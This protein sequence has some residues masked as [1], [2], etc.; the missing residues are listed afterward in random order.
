MNR[1]QMIAWLCIEGWESNWRLDPTH[2]SITREP[3]R[4][5]HG[6]KY[7][8]PSAWFT[9]PVEPPVQPLAW[10]HFTDAQIQAM[11]EKARLL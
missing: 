3:E 2:A 1:E 11:Y 8:N 10:T 4:I 6:G 9:Q 7:N 5:S